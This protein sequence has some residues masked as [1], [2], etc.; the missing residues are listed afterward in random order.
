M[1]SPI[2]QE[3]CL[4]NRLAPSISLLLS[5][6]GGRGVSECPRVPGQAGTTPP[7]GRIRP[8][9]WVSQREITCKKNFPAPSAPVC[10]PR[11]PP[12]T[13][14][15]PPRGGGQI[16]SAFECLP[17]QAPPGVESDLKKKPGPKSTRTLKK[18]HYSILCGI[19]LKL[20]WF[21]PTHKAFKKR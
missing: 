2:D 7:P 3:T 6:P 1:P 16:S 19:G 21:K 15:P 11:H 9:I 14:P 10:L 8:K 20:L 12:K 4:Q 13:L 5:Y 18:M 17:R